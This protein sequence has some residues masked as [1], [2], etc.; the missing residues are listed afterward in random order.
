MLFGK[1][2]FLKKNQGKFLLGYE[3][4]KSHVQ[5]SYIKMGEK[6][7]ETFSAVPGSEEYNIPLTLFRFADTGLWTFGKEATERKGDSRGIVFE[8]LLN[9]AFREKTVKA[10]E[11]IY[12]TA[13][14]LALFVKKSFSLLTLGGTLDQIGA[15]T[16]VIDSPEEEKIKVLRKVIEFLQLPNIEFHF[17]GK[18]ECF[19]YYTLYQDRELWK[20]QVYL[21]ELEQ[22]RLKSYCLIQNHNTTPVVTFIE[23]KSYPSL[24]GRADMSADEK[25]E[26]DEKFLENLQED[27]EGKIVSTVYLIG[28]GFGGEWYQKSVRYLCTK[29]RVF[30]GNNLFTKGACYGL[31]QLFLPGEEKQEFVYLG[32][33]KLMANVGLL[34]LQRGEETY[35]PV[36]DGGSSW[37]ESSKEWDFIIEQENRLRFQITPLDGKNVVYSEI[38]LNGLNLKSRKY[39]RLHMEISMETREKMVVKIW[40]KGFGEFYP[41]L[42]QYW[43]ESIRL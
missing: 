21:Y 7:P 28:D 41:S 34:V 8:N 3:L 33:D 29:R 2:G 23:K 16:F 14:L 9:L 43:E 6:E 22:E 13:A 5:I 18:E 24:P 12:E 31:R 11:E 1:E 10:E 30:L 36:L 15:C 27:M 26:R 17:M 25:E 19:F 20:N 38:I 39:T 35:L 4:A 32:E 37:Y 42:D 40:E